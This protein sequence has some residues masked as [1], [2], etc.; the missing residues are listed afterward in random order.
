MTWTSVSACTPFP[1]HTEGLYKEAA[2]CAKDHSADQFRQHSMSSKCKE[3]CTLESSC[4]GCRARRHGHTSASLLESHSL[5]PQ[6]EGPRACGDAELYTKELERPESDV[7]DIANIRL[8]FNKAKTCG[9]PIFEFHVDILCVHFR[10]DCRV[11]TALLCFTCVAAL[12]QISSSAILLLMIT[13]IVRVFVMHIFHGR[14]TTITFSRSCMCASIVP[15]TTVLFPLCVY[16]GGRTSGIGRATAASD[17]HIESLQC[18]TIR[19]DARYFPFRVSSIRLRLFFLLTHC[20]DIY[21]SSTP[22]NRNDNVVDDDENPSKS[23]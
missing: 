1:P 9:T 21:R 8:P 20:L 3:A 7:G 4:S 17:I 14:D 23:R 13:I 5:C 15:F 10:I 6:R 19:C 12:L 16:Q 22:S 11:V 2:C 18:R